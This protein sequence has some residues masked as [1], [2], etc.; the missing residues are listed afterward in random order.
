MAYFDKNWNELNDAQKRRMSDKYGGRSGWR[1][2]RSNSKSN[3]EPTSNRQENKN[4]RKEV[5]QTLKNNAPSGGPTAAQMRALKQSGTVTNDRAQQYLQKQIQKTRDVSQA[6]KS[7]RSDVRKSDTDYL[8]IDELNYNPNTENYGNRLEVKN[9]RLDNINRRLGKDS[10]SDE[11]RSELE[12]KQKEL[13]QGRRKISGQMEALEGFDKNDIST[14][15]AA[16]VG[17]KKFDAKDVAFLRQQGFD[18]EAITNYANNLDRSE[19]SGSAQVLDGFDIH[20]DNLMREDGSFD[21]TKIGASKSGNKFSAK[22]LRAMRASGMDDKEIAR[23]MYDQQEDST[24]SKKANKLLKKYVDEFTNTTPPGDTTGGD[25]SPIQG[26]TGDDSPN[27]SGGSGDDTVIS[28]G[29]GDDT[30]VTGDDVIVDGP[31]DDIYDGD[32]DDIYDGDGDDIYNDGNDNIFDGEGDDT[33]GDGNDDIT[34]GDN[35]NVIGDSGNIAED[36]NNDDFEDSFNGPTVGNIDVDGD[37]NNL[38]FSNNSRYYGGDNRVFQITYG[39]GSNNSAGGQVAAPASDLTMAGAYGIND[40]PSATAMFNDM[41]TTLNRDNQKKYDNVGTNTAKK[42]INL[43]RKAQ[44]SEWDRINKQISKSVRGHFTKA[45]K[46]QTL[47]FGDYENYNIPIFEFPEEQKGTD[48]SRIKDA[49]D[50]AED[51]LD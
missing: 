8:N 35:S 18:D 16:A 43:G 46:L 21:A 5:R 32:G 41:F 50:D 34:A 12:N 20:R 22:D 14:Y 36:I 24:R 47:G 15:N 29:S 51:A 27:Q 10:L 11:K 44:P 9:N 38:D 23:Q 42:Y 33:Y 28:G 19:V 25:D 2:A 3:N 13:R 31:G 4:A 37:N 49:A 40:S 26:S 17:K 30:I 6:L 7:D 1:E 48:T 45:D 39:G